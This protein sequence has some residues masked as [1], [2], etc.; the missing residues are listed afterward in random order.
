MYRKALL[1]LRIATAAAAVSALAALGALALYRFR[2]PK[3]IAIS[4][5]FSGS[6]D[7]DVV[8][9]PKSNNTN[10]WWLVD[11]GVVR[12]KLAGRAPLNYSFGQVQV[13][14]VGREIGGFIYSGPRGPDDAYA[15]AK[16]TLSQWNM[17]DS[18]TLR[19]LSAYSDFWRHPP[20][21]YYPQSHANWRARGPEAGVDVTETSGEAG[22]PSFVMTIIIWNPHLT[23]WQP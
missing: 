2:H 10:L 6:W 11:D 8:G 22:H 12:L 16:S 20:M 7:Q 17:D 18:G 19:S 4:W 23:Q 5:D 14:R 15:T 3:P 21:G 9:W 13:R 1:V